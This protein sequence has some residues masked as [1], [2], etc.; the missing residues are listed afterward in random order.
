MKNKDN[1]IVMAK[2][3]NVVLQSIR[4][5][6]TGSNINLLKLVILKKLLNLIK[7]LI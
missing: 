2:Y 6:K 4:L 1:N 3:A 5:I 7:P